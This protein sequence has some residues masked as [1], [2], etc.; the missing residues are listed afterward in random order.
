[1][2]STALNTTERDDG[3]PC[4]P[5][6]VLGVMM[7][8]ATTRPVKPRRSRNESRGIVIMEPPVS[9]VAKVGSSEACRQSWAPALMD[10][11]RR[12]PRSVPTAHELDG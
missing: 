4:A 11:D 8:A 7:K 12:S 2:A 6:M 5:T 9:D 1:M 10:D 3:D